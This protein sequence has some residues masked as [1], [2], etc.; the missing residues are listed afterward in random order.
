[1]ALKAEK[2]TDIKKVIL[3]LTKLN[4]DLERLIEKLPTNDDK[5]LANLNSS[6]NTLSNLLYVKTTDEKGSM[7][8]EQAV[9]KAISLRERYNYK[10]LNGGLRTSN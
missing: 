8:Y 4:S 5:I 3:E 2:R 1:M 6:F 7:F 10:V 9:G